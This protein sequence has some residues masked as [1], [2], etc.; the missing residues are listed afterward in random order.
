VPGCVLRMNASEFP[1]PSALLTTRTRSGGFLC[2]VSDADGDAFKT[3]VTDAQTF[4]SEHVSA[5]AAA[6]KS[7]GFDAEL[8]FGVWNGAPDVIAQSFTFPQSLLVLA[9]ACGVALTVSVYLGTEA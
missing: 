8:D 7:P 3:Q 9:A 2:T 6:A 1:L 4:L 5:L